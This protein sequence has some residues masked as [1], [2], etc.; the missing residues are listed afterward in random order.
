MTRPDTWG[1]PGPTF[2]AIYAIVA[3][4][5]V[6]VVVIRRLPADATRIDT[7]DLTAAQVGMLISDERAVLAA[8]TQLR[9]AGLIDS[10]GRATRELGEIDK[11]VHDTFVRAVHLRLPRTTTAPVR[12]AA[13]AL[14]ELRFTMSQQGLLYSRPRALGIG[15]L[16]PAILLGAARMVAGAANRKP[17]GYLALIV[18]CLVAVA[19]YCLIRPRRLTAR[20]AATLSAH[21]RANTLLEPRW[22]PALT[23]M[24]VR[25]CALATALFG[26]EAMSL[27]DARLA[28]N[29]AALPTTTA[30]RP[31]IARVATAPAPRRTHRRTTS[32]GFLGDGGGSDGGGFFGCGGGSSSCGGG[33]S[34]SSSCGGGGGGCGG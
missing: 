25:H 21:R 30:P 1:I 19:V 9:A 7:D 4:T 5:A 16:T 12:D 24:G 22:R 11:A 23:T 28:A 26:A 3:A 8:V 34:N 33:S 14:R 20:G 17:I 10:T 18:A 2:L 31:T 27:V 6:C 13:I 29:P 32:W 15:I